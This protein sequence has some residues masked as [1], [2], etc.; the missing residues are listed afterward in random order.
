MLKVKMCKGMNSIEASGN[1]V[2][3]CADVS[4]L[5]MSIYDGINDAD[6]K[7]FFAEGLKQFM[8]DGMYAKDTK[9]IKEECEKEKSKHKDLAKELK[10]SLEKLIDALVKKEEEKEEEEK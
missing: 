8:N 2:E 7:N 9:E 5:I 3:L 1:V 10:K 4:L 6:C